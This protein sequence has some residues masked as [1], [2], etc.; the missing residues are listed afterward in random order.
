M[1]L[2]GG[3]HFFGDALRHVSGNS[4]RSISDGAVW[5]ACGDYWLRP[6]P[7]AFNDPFHEQLL[8][9]ERIL[10]HRKY[11]AGR[12]GASLRYSLRVNCMCVNRDFDVF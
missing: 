7:S 1:R 4:V 9:V 12:T 10:S 2:V 11:F 6:Q 8:A 3:N 5:F